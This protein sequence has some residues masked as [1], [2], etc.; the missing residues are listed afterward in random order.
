MN[1]FWP[2]LGQNL[3]NK[4]NIMSIM[5]FNLEQLTMTMNKGPENTNQ[6]E[7]YVAKYSLMKKKTKTKT[8]L[9]VT[10]W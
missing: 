9:S 3:M 4:L 5:F 8:I 2:K 10:K 7:V 6:R 1:I